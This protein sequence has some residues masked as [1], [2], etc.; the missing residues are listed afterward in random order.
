MRSWR[1][2]AAP[3]RAWLAAALLAPAVPP[4]TVAPTATEPGFAVEF[5]VAPGGDDSNPGT[6]DLPFATLERGRAAVRARKSASGLPPG[7]VAVTIRGGMYQRSETF[8]LDARDSGAE[9]RPV[10]YRSY[11]GEHVRLIGG[12]MLD[13]ARFT[14]VTSSSPLW[15]RID[16]AAR[17]NL[18]QI[19]LQTQGIAD[20]GV[21][22]PRGF[23]TRAPAALELFFNGTRMTLGRWPDPGQTDRLGF[24]PSRPVSGFVAIVTA[25]S[26]TRFTYAGTRP[27]RWR[28]AREVWVHGYFQHP[29]AD[30]HLPVS[31]I[32]LSTR[33][34]SVQR[35]PPF[36]IATRGSWYAENLLEEV[37]TAGEWWIDRSTG[38]L[39]FWPPAPISAG[40]AV[41]STLSAPLVSTHGSAYLEF[42]DITFEVG[43]GDLVHLSGDNCVLRNC[44]LRNAGLRGAVV[45]G[46]HSGVDRCQVY[47]TGDGGVSLSGGDR[48]T[49]RP[50]GNYVRNSEIHDFGQ[51][52]FTYTPGVQVEGVGQVVSH[53]VI[54][55]APFGAVLFRGNNHVVE[56]NEIHHVCQLGSDEGA[57]YAGRDWGYRG[58]EIRFNFIHDVRAAERWASDFATHGIYLDDCV[59]GIHVHGNVL[60]QIP[61]GNAFV[62]GG[63]RDDIIENNVIARCGR[64]FHADSRGIEEITAT[65]GSEWN[66]LERLGLDGIR[67]QRDPWASAYPALAAIPN[68]PSRIMDPKQLWRYPQGSV[69]SRNLGFANPKWVEQDDRGGTGTFD[70]FAQIA[71]NIPDEDPLFADEAQLDLALLPGSPAFRIP[72]F[73]PIPFD[74]IGIEPDVSWVHRE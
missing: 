14:A 24:G 45:S 38:I 31:A 10:V 23:L 8:S 54:R 71:D 22:A 34:I 72:G 68:S 30:M 73:Q 7:G 5:F 42:R 55:D 2:P 9:G 65:R 16:P 4:E 21:L 40:E 46:T 51:W 70:K 41:V 48:A 29:W 26:S 74:R 50:G 28:S 49:L 12:K 47:G 11:P 69:F 32:D 52:S 19:D 1:R 57:V 18:V 60:Y 13:G 44:T 39:Y 53:N 15:P 43:R 37:T 67:Y 35:P 36:G 27:E 58:N 25:P 56:Y 64:A 17:G 20:D 61:N 33:T 63:G 6:K 66:L 3:A 59:S 62:L